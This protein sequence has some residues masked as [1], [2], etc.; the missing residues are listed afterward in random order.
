LRVILPKL[1]PYLKQKKELSKL[2]VEWL[3]TL[4]DDSHA[5]SAKPS[6]IQKREE[7]LRRFERAELKEKSWKKEYSEWHFHEKNEC[8]G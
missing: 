7:I 2:M 3:D 8:T 5:N 6:V 1:I 4:G